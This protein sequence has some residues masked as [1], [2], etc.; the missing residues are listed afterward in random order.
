[1]AAGATITC[2]GDSHRVRDP[3]QRISA[4]AVGICATGIRT[5]SLRFLRALHTGRDA[6]KPKLWARFWQQEESRGHG[7]GA[8]NGIRGTFVAGGG[9][10]RALA[11]DEH[12]CD[13]AWAATESKTAAGDDFKNWI[14]GC[15]PGGLDGAHP[16]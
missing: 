4:S 1:M 6:E 9:S 3:R 13:S 12:T 2:A 7:L 5:S 10:P 8:R 16:R 11:P 15:T 14:G